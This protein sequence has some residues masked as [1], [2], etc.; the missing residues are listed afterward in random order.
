MPARKTASAADVLPRR[1][2]PP[3]RDPT[4]PLKYGKP[5]VG[6]LIKMIEGVSAILLPHFREQPFS[7]QEH[8]WLVDDWYE[9][10]LGNPLFQR[11]VLGMFS[12]SLY[13]RLGASNVAVFGSRLVAYEQGKVDRVNAE[14]TSKGME[15]VKHPLPLE[16]AALVVNAAFVTRL[17][18]E[19]QEEI[20]ATLQAQ[21]EMDD[22]ES[23]RARNGSGENGQREDFLSPLAT[24]A[25]PSRHY[26][27]DEGR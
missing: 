24:Q 19:S 13:L 22:V 18:A 10:G 1:A 11:L 27:R 7:E 2:A 25:A 12:N 17:A 14:R 9:F 26:A 16:Q 5:V 8:D 23:G 20:I 21:E 4:K 15:P 3:K 6:A